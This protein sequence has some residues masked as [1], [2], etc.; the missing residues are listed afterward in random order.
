MLLNYISPYVYFLFLLS[1]SHNYVNR[2]A[3]TESTSHPLHGC[4]EQ[5]IKCPEWRFSKVTGATRQGR[6]TVFGRRHGVAEK[7]GHTLATPAQTPHKILY[8]FFGTSCTSSY[9]PADSFKALCHVRDFMFF[10]SYKLSF[11]SLELQIF[12]IILPGKP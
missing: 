5:I 6:V 2:Q 1:I 9:A 4:D 7:T 10:Y 11:P 12:K 3:M 8:L